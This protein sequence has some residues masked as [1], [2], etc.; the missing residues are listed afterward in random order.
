MKFVAERDAFLKVLNHVTGVVDKKGV[1]PILRNVLLNASPDGLHVTATD[2]D[3]EIIDSI[4]AMVE[5]GGRTTLPAAMLHDILKRLPPG[6]QVKVSASE[7]MRTSVVSGD[8]R[9][10]VAGLPAQDFPVMTW[11]ESGVHIFDVAGAD[12]RS[13][14]DKSKIAISTEE[15]RYY[16]NGIYFHAPSG[17]NRLRSVATNG[18]VLMRSDIALPDGAAGMPHVIVP[19]KAVLELRRLIDSY[20]EYVTVRVT[21]TKIRFEF[22]ETN[23]TSK[24]IDGTFP[25]YDRVI[26]P[27]GQ[28]TMNVGRKALIDAID[29]VAFVGE[30]RSPVGLG[31]K[32]GEPLELSCRHPDHG[33]AADKLTASYD[34]SPIE[35]GFN[36]TY[37]RNILSSLNA[38]NA[39]FYLADAGSPALIEGEGDAE[40]LG[41]VMPMRL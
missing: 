14:I 27:R 17:A 18:H 12:M 7:S 21:D 39:T 5:T 40:T 34:G 2:L 36:P 38:E 23:L 4:P 37:M 30:N 32:R 1:I 6:S 8:A 41:V 19:R 22:G 11:P 26:P 31:L 13:L 15:T 24:L 9:Y 29:R 10:Q 28:N 16:L 20:S 25:D 35:V 33:D 3:I